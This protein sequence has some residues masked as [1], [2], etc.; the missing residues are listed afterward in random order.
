[1]KSLGII[2]NKDIFE[3]NLL[4]LGLICANKLKLLICL[5]CAYAIIVPGNISGDLSQYQYEIIELAFTNGFLKGMSID[6]DIINE[7]LKDKEKLNSFVRKAA[8][9]YMDKVVELNWSGP[10]ERGV[11]KVKSKEKKSG[12][13]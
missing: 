10:K 3:V 6:E 8:R 9:D 7:L 11:E 1:M 2:K 4:E 13:G 5:I 12:K